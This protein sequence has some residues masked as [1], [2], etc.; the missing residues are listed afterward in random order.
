MIFQVLLAAS[1]AINSI[2]ADNCSTAPY[3][4]CGS[5]TTAVSCCPSGFYCQPWNAGYYQCMKTP[6]QCSNQYTNVD[7]LGNTIKTI[8]GVQPTDCCS[9]IGRAH[10]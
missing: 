9:Q 1:L 6:D 8:Y 3:A 10:V 2:L 7:L 5:D 4:Q